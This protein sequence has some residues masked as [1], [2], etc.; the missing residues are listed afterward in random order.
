M[1]F[2]P[3]RQKRLRK[4]CEGS[5]SS[6]AANRTRNT[7]KDQNHFEI[8]LV[9]KLLRSSLSITN[10]CFP[11]LSLDFPETRSLNTIGISVIVNP[12]R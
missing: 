12:L 3:E 8:S 10:D 9:L 2:N 4:T 1:V 6:N 11:S 5:Y 7:A